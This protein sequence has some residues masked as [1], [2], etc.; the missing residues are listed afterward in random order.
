MKSG[1]EV[2]WLLGLE[3]AEKVASA[4][5]LRAPGLSWS[6]WNGCQYWPLAATSWARTGTMPPLSRNGDQ[7]SQHP[8]LCHF[9]GSQVAPANLVPQWRHLTGTMGSLA[10]RGSHVWQVATCLEPFGHWNSKS[11]QCIAPA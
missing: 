5:L 6:K 10:G 9:A 8:L 1:G 3:V 2:T 4:E 7:L 11:H